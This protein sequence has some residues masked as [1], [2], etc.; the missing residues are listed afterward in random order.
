[1][2]IAE[3]I[4]HD[5]RGNI[6]YMREPDGAEA[7]FTETRPVLQRRQGQLVPVELTSREKR[8]DDDLPAIGEA[9]KTWLRTGEV[10][11]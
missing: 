2:A 4:G 10:S 6:I 3:A 8:I 9:Y 5:R 7:V 11:V 1:M